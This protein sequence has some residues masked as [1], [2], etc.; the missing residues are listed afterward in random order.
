MANIS[1]FGGGL[2]FHASVKT[3]NYTIT[4]DEDVGVDS[5][6]GAFTITLKASPLAGDVAII[7]DVGQNCGTTNVAI[8][9]NGSTINGAAADE[10]LD[11]DNGM[12]MFVYNGSTWK[13]TP[14][15]GPGLNEAEVKAVTSGTQ[16]QFLRPGVDLVMGPSATPTYVGG[17]TLVTSYWCVNYYTMSA[18][19]DKHVYWTV[20]MQPR[21]NLGTFR[22][23]WIWAADT[24]NVGVVR[25]VVYPLATAV[26]DLETPSDSIGT[27]QVV[28]DTSSGVVNRIQYTDWSAAVTHGSVANDKLIS[29]I[30]MRQ[31]SAV[32]DTFTG[33]GKLLGVEVEW[34][35]DQ[36][37][38]A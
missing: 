18:T 12:Y 17:A 5:S 20:P 35:S 13:F 1:R 30:L 23:R 25:W 28:D 7:R 4:A 27:P 9:R 29:F 31:G 6:G 38:D 37:T 8:A 24:T 14:F 3:A 34:T 32:A 26:G 10:N 36:P 19:V 33:A 21:Y 11:V 22:F 2:G 16:R 15:S